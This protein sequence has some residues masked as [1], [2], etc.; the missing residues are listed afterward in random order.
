[1]KLRNYSWVCIQELLLNDTRNRIQV[2]LLQGKHSVMYCLFGPA[3]VL[4][5]LNSISFICFKRGRISLST[6]H[7]TCCEVCPDTCWH[8]GGTIT[9][10]IGE[11]EKDIYWV[12]VPPVKADLQK[13]RPN[14]KR[15]W[16][17]WGGRGEGSP[18][19]LHGRKTFQGDGSQGWNSGQSPGF[20]SWT[21]A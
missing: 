3:K 1:M 18:T 11:L 2:S 7:W 4:N 12:I 19:C 10:A 6:Q 8:I 13:S 20:G 14:Q 17:R 21:T 9:W 5:D 15:T 16:I